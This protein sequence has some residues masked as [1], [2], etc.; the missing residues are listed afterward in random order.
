LPVTAQTPHVIKRNRERIFDEIE[1]GV[2]IEKIAGLPGM[3]AKRTYWASSDS[4]PADL[5]FAAL[6]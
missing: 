3:P 4:A 5:K 6:P 1:C 2:S